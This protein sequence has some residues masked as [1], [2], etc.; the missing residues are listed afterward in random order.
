MA[1]TGIETENRFN[2][3]A[4][5]WL[6][7]RRKRTWALAAIIVYTLFGFFGVPWLVERQLVN[8]LA[9]TGREASVERIRA[10][11]YVLSMDVEGLR[12]NDTDGLEIVSL[13][14]L[15][16]NFQLSS[17]FHWAATF[18]DVRIESPHLTEERFGRLDTRFTR[19][20][21]DLAGDEVEEPGEESAPPRVI[22]G[23][24]VLADG[25]VHLVD[26]S[27]G[28]FA[29]DIGPISVD[30]FDIRTLPDNEGHHAVTVR[31]GDRNRVEWQGDLSIVPLRSSGRLALVGHGIEDALRY[32]D[33]FLPFSTE[34]G[35]IEIGLDYTF[36]L[37]S[38]ALQLEVS[39]LSGTVDDIRVTPDGGNASVFAAS[40]LG[41]VNG[42]ALLPDATIDV[43]RVAV[44]GMEITAELRP[45]GSI[46]LV[47]LV[48]GSD[49]ATDTPDWD[50][51]DDT[52]WQ[53]TV[54]EVRVPGALIHATDQSMSPPVSVDLVELDLRLT[55]LDSRPGTSMPVELATS[56]SSG[57][58]VAYNGELTL[59]PALLTT[60]RLE[61]QAVALPVVQPYIEPMLRIEMQSGT[62][63]MQADLT[64]NPDQLLDL[65]G[66][67]RVEQLEVVDTHQEERLLGWSAMTLDR[68]ELD[69]AAQ[70]LQTSEVLFD[71]LYGRVHVAEDRSTN[72]SDLLV[73]PI[74]P[75]G[76]PDTGSDEAPA[77]AAPLAITVGGI[78]LDDA[79]L[80]FSDFSLPL[81]FQA[82]IRSLDGDI[83]TLS[84]VSVEPANV[85]LKGQV[86]E[87][88][89]ARIGG[90]ID[91]WDPTRNTDIAM[92]FRNLEMARLTP[93][94]IQFAGY[95][96]DGG[97]L[98]MDLQY[99]LDQR[100]MNGDNNIVIRE[101]ELGEKVETEDGGSLP[102][103]LAIALLKDTEGV[104]DVDVPVEGDLDDPQFRIAGVVWRA[105][106][107]LITRAVT[108]PFRLLGALVG[109]EDED[110]GT[111]HFTP[112]QSELSPPDREKMVKLGDAM[113]QRP[114]LALS[115]GGVHADAV[116]RPAL[117]RQFLDARIDA[118][119]A[120]HPGDAD[121]L[122]TTRQR[123]TLEALFTETFPGQPLEAVQA[124]FT[125]PP[126]AATGDAADAG[127]P[128]L[129][130]PAYV[131]GLDKRLVD[132]QTVT[133]ADLQS[134]AEARAAAVITALQDAHPEAG[135]T[136]ATAAVEAT[137]ASDGNEVPLELSVE[138]GED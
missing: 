120:D 56:L 78:R 7:W 32:T 53:I 52:P 51:E 48:P 63:D 121:E 113:L 88:G 16:A 75:P 125:G 77:S 69:M 74:A 14:R 76:E 101:I 12:I 110:F 85:D 89:E 60:G 1:D 41:I 33:H 95:A 104:I 127:A 115:V 100:R 54:A 107:N 13:G 25:R 129:D 123:R 57:G 36:D 67:L 44:E 64:H 128:V 119:Q 102:L 96:I 66:A 23:H 9:D 137:E 108:A 70:Q 94:T 114:E 86:N 81:P 87:Y 15:F 62:V 132:A 40:R 98:D 99:R 3:L 82:A 59:L 135:L 37:Q 4:R 133:P 55:G 58:R 49:T 20:L 116:D 92:T 43:E 50:D 134:L 47:D 109:I 31:F 21:A 10:N 117:Q 90:T 118:W 27:A 29:T 73:E 5:H 131:A 103:G 45:D 18:R 19:M 79:S 84:T 80:D 130:E 93:Y 91:A 24:F 122:S 46:N 8:T 124:E 35:D 61:L 42:H 136:V 138:A 11:P 83:S 26:R 28:D 97:R 126:P 112:G 34:V 17:L 68:F 39:A 38:E 6:H 105:I 65:A 111:L 30:V 2:T 22:V 106:G 72:I 71:R